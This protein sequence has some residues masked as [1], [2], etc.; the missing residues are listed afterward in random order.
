MHYHYV[1]EKVLVGDI[2]LVYVNTQEQVADIFTKSLGVEKMQR[3]QAMLG[4]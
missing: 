3:F 4:V 1:H 2:D